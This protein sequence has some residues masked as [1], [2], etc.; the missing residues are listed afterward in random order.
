MLVTPVMLP[1]LWFTLAA[2]LLRVVLTALA[3]LPG[4]LLWG[5]SALTVL[6]VG[7]LL[8]GSLALTVL[9]VGLLL[10]GSLALVALPAR[11]VRPRVRGC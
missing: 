5:S 2:L 1:T 7:L 3:A 10:G 4:L 6:P 8:S 9:P 11:L